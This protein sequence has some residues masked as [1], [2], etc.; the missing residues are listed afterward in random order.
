MAHN[1][2]KNPVEKGKY[3]IALLGMQTGMDVRH[4]D[5]DGRIRLVSFCVFLG[6]FCGDA[7]KCCCPFAPLDNF[8]Q[9]LCLR[10]IC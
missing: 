6:R 8:F 7:L 5:R 2:K 4:A 3:P 9:A 1:S 10:L